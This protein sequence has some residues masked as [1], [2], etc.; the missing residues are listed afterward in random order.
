MRGVS[1]VGTMGTRL[2]GQTAVVIGGTTGIGRA[3]SEELHAAGASVV[4]TSRTETSVREAAEAVECDLV[5]P[6][7]VT[8]ADQ[9]EVLFEA[10]AE[11][12]GDIDTLVNCA[13][14]VP[15]AKP[16]PDVDDDEWATV[17]DVNLTGV[18]NAVR[19]APSYLTGEHRSIVNVGS[20]SE[21]TVM[22]GLGHYA[23]SKAAVR[24][25]GEYLA[26]EYADYDIRV[27]TVAPGYVETRQNRTELETPKIREAIHKGTP[28]SRYAERGEVA[29]AVVFLASP[30]ASFVTGETIRIDGGFPL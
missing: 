10:V 26:V 14:Y 29:D 8:D 30:E 18:F 7:D 9:V 17:L 24:T 23:A 6:T 2:D 1:L 16:V 25:L 3:I 28:L 22:N 27:N 11:T 19:L 5:E 4:P 15:D 12:Y 20:I 21:D 13:G